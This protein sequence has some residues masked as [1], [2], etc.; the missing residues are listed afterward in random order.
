ML[1]GRM[2]L[3]APSLDSGAAGCAW[4]L[5]IGAGDEPDGTLPPVDPVGAEPVGPAGLW[6]LTRLAKFG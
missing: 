4:K 6:E 3:V 1:S 2:T 5:A